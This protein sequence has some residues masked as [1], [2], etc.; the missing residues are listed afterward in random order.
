MSIL[1]EIRDMALAL[2][3]RF[4]IPKVAGIVFPPFSPGNQPK[5]CEFMTMALQGGAGW[6]SYVLTPDVIIWN[7]EEHGKIVAEA[8]VKLK[9]LLKAIERNIHI[10]KYWRSTE[11]VN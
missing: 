9:G 8:L 6:I 3:S 7:I 1:T 11:Y 5:D 2:S 10:L 4:F